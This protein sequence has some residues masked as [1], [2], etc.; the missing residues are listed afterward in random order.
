MTA[1]VKKILPMY[2]VEEGELTGKRFTAAD[3]EKCHAIRKACTM[4]DLMKE[5]TGF[6]KGL[7][8]GR[9]IV[10]EMKQVLHKDIGY[11]M[12]NADEHR[13]DLNANVPIK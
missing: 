1:L 2:L 13:P 7:K 11:L 3:L 10:N 6:A 4:D 5:A 8:K 9:W 12:D